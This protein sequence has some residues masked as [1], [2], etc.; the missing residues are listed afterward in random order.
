MADQTAD[1]FKRQCIEKMGEQLGSQFSALWQEV[2]VLHLNWKE[3]VEL[4]GTKPERVE[5][6][7]RAA[8]M[9]FHMI[10]NEGWEACLLGLARLTD[11]PKSAGRENL[12]I[13]NLPTLIDDPQA[14]AKV[15]GLVDLALKSTEFCRDWQ[16]RYIAHRDLSLAL[17]EPTKELAEGNRAKANAALK[18]VADVL[19]A[20][21][22]HYMDAYTP[23]DFASR[24]HGAVSLLHLIH[25][26]LKANEQREA[27][28]LKGEHSEDD[29]DPDL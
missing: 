4:F 27:R 11:P 6:L 8:P 26:G 9:F 22:G 28:I 15:K 21:Q 19:N 12:T 24:Y 17:K 23:F 18:A 10:Q 16:H 29:F 3:Y 7:N 20:V 25:R 13:Q 2:A 5:I 1:E 14:K